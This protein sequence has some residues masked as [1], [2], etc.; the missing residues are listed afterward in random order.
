M[1]AAGD[2]DG[3]GVLV[4]AGVD[5][6]GVGVLVGVPGVLVAAGVLVGV[7]GDVARTP[8]FQALADEVRTV[9]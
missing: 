2:P 3:V 6:T 9:I 4:A 8:K 5:G 7:V 1:T